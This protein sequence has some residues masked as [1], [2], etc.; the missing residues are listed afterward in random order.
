MDQLIARAAHN[1]VDDGV[2]RRIL[3]LNVS[4][5]GM[6]DSTACGRPEFGRG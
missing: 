3:V 2:F 6:R 1:Y 5:R 4:E